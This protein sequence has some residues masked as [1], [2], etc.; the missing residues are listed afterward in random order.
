MGNL[1]RLAPQLDDR[2][3]VLVIDNASPLP[4]AP[5]ITEW[6][7]AWPTLDVRCHLPGESA[8]SAWAPPCGKVIVDVLTNRLNIGGLSNVLRAFEICD[9]E[10]MWILGDDDPVQ[11][12]AVQTIF[13]HF[14]AFPESLY[15]SFAANP[16]QR[17]ESMVVKGCDELIEHMSSYADTL[18]IS[19]GVY[20]V[21]SFHPSIKIGYRYIYAGAAH[22]AI[23]LA[24]LSQKGC[25]CLSKAT[26]VDRAPIER[27]QR[28][29][30]LDLAMGINT[31]LDLPM[32]ANSIRRLARLTRAALAA[33]QGIPHDSATHP[34]AKTSN[35]VQIQILYGA[36]Y[37]TDLQAG[38]YTLGIASDGRLYFPLIK[39]PKSLAEGD[40]HDCRVVWPDSGRQLSGGQDTREGDVVGEPPFMTRSQSAYYFAFIC[41]SLLCLS[42]SKAARVSGASSVAIAVY[43]LMANSATTMRRLGYVFVGFAVYACLFGLLVVKNSGSRMHLLLS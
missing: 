32:G 17:Q 29:S 41:A 31:L 25:C 1:Q 20:R 2:T 3:R 26:L 12:G 34:A 30:F 28:W 5:L 9:S 18:L 15:I 23:L 27:H 33:R 39:F 42:P 43:G 19:I 8:S 21:R 7:K 6:A 13:Q 35:P 14:A 22:F 38:S 16:G 37:G 4:V 24:A 40:D 11:A 10:W 36:L